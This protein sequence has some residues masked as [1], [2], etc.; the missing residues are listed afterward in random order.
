MKS[1]FV[2][3]LPALTLTLLLSGCWR[4]STSGGV[5]RYHGFDES[6]G[7]WDVT[8][9]A[10]PST[11]RT[12]GFHIIE[13]KWAVDAKAAWYEG[14]PVHDPDSDKPALLDGKSFKLLSGGFYAKD[15][16][17]VIFTNEVVKANPTNFKVF[18]KVWGYDGNDVYYEGSATEHCTSKKLYTYTLKQA[19]DHYLGNIPHS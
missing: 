8:L 14:R 11:F 3:A 9:T 4:Y 6:N 1:S 12:I 5:V 10:D 2:R 15:R 18:D 16:Q 17:H 7:S 13:T 19:C